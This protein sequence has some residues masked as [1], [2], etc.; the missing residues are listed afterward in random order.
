MNKIMAVLIINKRCHCLFFAYIQ[1]MIF[2]ILQSVHFNDFSGENTEDEIKSW[3]EVNEENGSCTQ[4]SRGVESISPGATL[5][6]NSKSCWA[7][8]EDVEPTQLKL[9]CPQLLWLLPLQQPSSLNNK[10][11]TRKNFISVS[12]ICP[13]KTQTLPFL[14][15]KN[16]APIFENCLISEAHVSFHCLPT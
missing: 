8:S 1:S 6:A 15:G 7:S 3:R 4:K 10:V 9:L 16:Q 13:G 2:G 5:W 11:K 12:Y 14:S